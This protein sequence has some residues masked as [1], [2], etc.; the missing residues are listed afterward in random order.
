MRKALYKFHAS[1]KNNCG[2]PPEYT[3]LEEKLNTQ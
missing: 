3:A 2:M 1:S